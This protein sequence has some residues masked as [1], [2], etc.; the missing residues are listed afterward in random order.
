MS[1]EGAVDAKQLAQLPDEMFSIIKSSS[2][3]LGPRLGRLRLPGR[4]VLETPTFLATTS[5]G[6][7]PHITQDTFAQATGIDG[8]YIPLE[9]CT[10][11]L[12]SNKLRRSTL[13]HMLTA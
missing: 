12:P 10:S 8:V 7:V 1:A 9:D 13:T 5:R 4:T 11:K 2:N 6:V 3:A